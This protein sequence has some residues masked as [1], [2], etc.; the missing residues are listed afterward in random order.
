M[1]HGGS[2]T[3]HHLVDL[4]EV[5]RA[6]ASAGAAVV[7]FDVD[8]TLY[9]MDSIRWRFLWRNRARLRAVRV[10]RAVRE[11]LRETD[12]PDGA[13]L[14]EAEARL[15]A[16]RL[17]VPVERARSVLDDIFGASLVD[18]V[19]RV[20]AGPG[21]RDGLQALVRSGVSIAVASDRPAQRKLVALGLFDLPWAAVICADDT[22]ALKPSARVLGAVARAAHCEPTQ[23][24][25]VGDR[26]DTDG[27]CAQ[28]VG[29]RFVLT[30]AFWDA[31]RR[32]P[33][34]PDFER[35]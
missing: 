18:V 13:A 29:A 30:D 25:H 14:R 21:V 26:V 24:I 23:I 8:G 17:E 33:T 9:R 35:R 1:P 34:S 7:S 11:E 19:A 28:N 6:P 32:L 10:G 5:L 4:Q 2:V 20:G 15:A 16:E 31:C 3:S 27:A 22:G 12:F